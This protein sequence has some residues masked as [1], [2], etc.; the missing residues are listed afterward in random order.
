MLLKGFELQHLEDAGGLLKIPRIQHLAFCHLNP[1][2]NFK[3]YEYLGTH[4]PSL[5]TITTVIQAD[6]E[7]ENI[8]M[9][10][11][12]GF[13]GDTL[14]GPN[15]EYRLV[16]LGTL[17][18]SDIFWDNPASLLQSDFSSCTR[19]VLKMLW[20][21]ART[22]LARTKRNLCQEI[23]SSPTLS[24]QKWDSID[25]KV[26]L[27]AKED[28]LSWWSAEILYLIPKENP[29][30]K[31]NE[32][33]AY[34]TIRP[35]APYQKRRSRL[36]IEVDR[37]ILPNDPSRPSVIRGGAKHLCFFSSPKGEDQ[38]DL[39]DGVSRM[40]GEESS[41][42][43]AGTQGELAYTAKFKWDEIEQLVY[44]PQA[45]L[46][47][48]VEIISSPVYCKRYGSRSLERHLWNSMNGAKD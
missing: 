44:L 41:R 21:D 33:Y 47:G 2:H 8:K 35:I 17:A 16:D 36:L 31:E 6:N 13:R 38:D 25:F 15:Y 5:K 34:Y 23:Q 32:N 27:M 29:K 42:E 22:M 28:H 45:E 10:R 4:F 24:A 40:F 12:F 30:E 26:C 3:F 9:H 7:G 43:V 1:N 48:H 39:Y 37:F 20:I 14:K 19:T 18:R 46:E 11:D